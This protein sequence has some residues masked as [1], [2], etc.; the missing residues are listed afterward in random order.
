[1]K[2]FKILT[3][4]L[5]LALV[6]SCSNIKVLATKKVEDR[7]GLKGKNILVIAKTTDP[8][9][10]KVFEDQLTL[11]MNKMGLQ[12]TQS[13]TLFPKIVPESE[14]TEERQE[15]IRKKIEDAGYNA[16]VLC[17]LQDHQEITREVGTGDYYASVNYGYIDWPTYMGWGFYTYYYHPLSY[18]TEDIYVENTS[19]TITT[20]LYIVD[21]IAFNLDLPKEEQFV[22]LV[23]A[24]VENPESALG[25]A[26]TYARAIAKA[27]KKS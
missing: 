16:V 9:V 12:G 2:N 3:G 8:D 13:Y 5:L 10:R 21:T 1:M 20:Q 26:Q 18:S 19:D 15:L 22:G 17:R 4:V 27:V 25:T 24:Q 7:E 23:R 6:S 14:L 11:E